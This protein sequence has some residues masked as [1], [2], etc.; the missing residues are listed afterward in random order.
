M[1]CKLKPTLNQIEFD[2]RVVGLIWTKI[3]AFQRKI[4]EPRVSTMSSSQGF[5]Y[6]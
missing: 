2:L 4:P 5:A 3:Y 1:L 6:K